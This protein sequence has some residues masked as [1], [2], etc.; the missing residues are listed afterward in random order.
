[1]D[2][3]NRTWGLFRNQEM[4]TIFSINSAGH[5]VIGCGVFPMYKNLFLFLL[6]DLG[7]KLKLKFMFHRLR[8]SRIMYNPA[9]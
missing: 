3:N 1:M 2:I 5:E 4:Q 7:R 8:P 6:R 9:T